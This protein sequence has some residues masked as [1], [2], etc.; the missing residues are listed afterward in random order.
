M[1]YSRTYSIKIYDCKITTIIS[2]DVLAEIRK[3]YKKN[4]EACKI[5]T[6]VKGFVVYWDID[7]YYM[8]FNTDYIV[9]NTICHELYHLMRAI[10]R[11]RALFDEETRACLMGLLGEEHHTFLRLKNILIEK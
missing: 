7:H 8:L 11:P 9:M 1:R 10:A 3:L 4:G 2:D 5:V 6:N